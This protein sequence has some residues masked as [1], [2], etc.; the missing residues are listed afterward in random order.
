M[1]PWGR[2]VG[3]PGAIIWPGGHK[4]FSY[5]NIFILAARGQTFYTSTMYT[6]H[7]VHGLYTV[8]Y[9]SVQCTVYRVYSVH[10]TTLYTVQSIGQ[11]C[12]LG[13]IRGGGVEVFG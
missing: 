9:N 8:L 7:T 3:S 4:S 12:K 1:E 6:V 10:F 2:L 13:Y 5:S 11:I